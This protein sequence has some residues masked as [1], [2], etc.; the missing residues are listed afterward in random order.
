MISMNALKK[1]PGKT[2]GAVGGSMV[3]GVVPGLIA[4]AVVDKN[5]K[6]AQNPLQDNYTAAQYQIDPEKERIA[7]EALQARQNELRQSGQAMQGRQAAVLNQSAA[8]QMRTGQMDFIN[9][10]QDQIA[11]RGG[12]SAAQ[13]QLRSASDDAMRQALAFAASSRGN[14]ALAM[15]QADRSRAMASQNAANQSSI[16]RAQESQAAQGLLANTLQGARGQDLSA[17]QANLQ[18]ELSQRGLNDNMSQFYDAGINSN[19]QSQLANAFDYE[20]LK[21][22]AFDSFEG[23]RMQD[24]MERARR[25]QQVLSG[26]LSGASTAGAAAIGG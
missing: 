17:A 7:R 3:G 2:I 15:Q 14:P 20:R 1:N 22:G 11:G 8:N 10:L 26:V 4:G 19:L 6:N 23:R 13:A 25:N 5:I 16:L 21:A 12:P 24:E 9:Q 18:S